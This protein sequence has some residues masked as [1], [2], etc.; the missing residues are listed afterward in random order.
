MKVIF[1]D[2]DGVLNCRTTRQRNPAGFVGVEPEK[3]QILRRILR[4]TGAHI[5]LSS[6]WRKMPSLLPHL[7]KNIGEHYTRRVVGQT[8]VME[9]PTEG[10]L[11]HAPERGVEIQAWLDQNLVD[12]FV[13]IDDDA[14]MAHLLPHLVQTDNR[15]G[16]TEVEAKEIIR[17]LNA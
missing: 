8:P 1:L 6:T 13:I 4:E 16:L 5:V 3:C 15:L 14:D 17:R 7:W 2:V 10:G 12:Q 11:L 9:K